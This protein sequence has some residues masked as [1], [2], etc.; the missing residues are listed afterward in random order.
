MPDV[1]NGKSLGKH[2]AMTQPNAM[3]IVRAV[4]LVL[5]SLTAFWSL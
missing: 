2:E 4:R 1:S 5:V 3:N